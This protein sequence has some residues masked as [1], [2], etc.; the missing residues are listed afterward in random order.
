MPR[1][2]RVQACAD[3]R[4]RSPHYDRARS[5]AFYD[6]S[7][8][9]A[10]L[11][12]KYQRDLALG[13]AFA[14]V[15]AEL[16]ASLD[17]SFDLVCVVPLARQRRLQRGYN[18]V[19]LFARPLAF[20][21][22]RPYRPRALE[23]SRET[24]SQVGLGIDERWENV[25]RAFAARRSLVAGKHVLLLDDVMTTG[26]TLSSAA[27]SLKVAGA[28]AVNALSIARARPHEHV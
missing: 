13:L 26:A 18:Q 21:L 28:R 17:W 24:D 1:A 2:R 6:G 19:E 25:R 22:R 14:R 3:C 4:S 20:A 10:L 8:R 16:L 23:R 7:L 11:E 15:L 12:L 5:W 9:S 27:R